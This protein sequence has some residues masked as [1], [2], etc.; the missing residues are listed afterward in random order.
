MFTV[1]AALIGTLVAVWRST[2]GGVTRTPDGGTETGAGGGVLRAPD[3]GVAKVGASAITVGL[4]FCPSAKDIPVSRLVPTARQ[5]MPFF[6][7]GS[8]LL[9]PMVLARPN[10]QHRR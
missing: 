10:K 9:E 7:S 1:C 5:N 8:I 4:G 6:K 2:A 3:G